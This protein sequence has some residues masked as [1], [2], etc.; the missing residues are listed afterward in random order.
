MMAEC[1]IRVSDAGTTN[2]S[3]DPATV[4]LLI[5]W[6]KLEVS[7]RQVREEFADRAGLSL[8][9][10]QTLV[11]L[12]AK[13]DSTP[14]AVGLALGLTTGATTALIDRLENGGYVT[15]EPHPTDRRSTRL[16]LTDTGLT[17]ATRTGA[18]YFEVVRST[19]PPED[20]AS[21]TSLFSRLADALDA[22]LGSG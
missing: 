11:F 6:Q 9:D 15:R 19:V 20:L 16:V 18:R 3:F 10:F 12:S 7:S 5:A 13:Q 21:V 2:G 4:E 14:K 17:A 8:N 22:T 1:E